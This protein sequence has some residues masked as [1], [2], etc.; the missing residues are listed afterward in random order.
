VRPR[1][2]PC[3]F[4]AVERPESETD[5]W[6]GRMGI[7]PT[8]GAAQRRG[9]VRPRQSAE[10]DG[11]RN[12]A[13]GTTRR[14]GFVDRG[15]RRLTAAGIMWSQDQSGCRKR[16]LGAVRAPINQLHKLKVL[17]SQCFLVGSSGTLGR[18]G[19]QK[20]TTSKTRQSGSAAAIERVHEGILALR[21]RCP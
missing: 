10:A 3:E 11:N 19:D 1:Q 18:R 17:L 13:P 6:R 12:H 5:A 15:D 9:W 21:E 7:E 2:S 4:L 20:V 14:A 16:C 8:P